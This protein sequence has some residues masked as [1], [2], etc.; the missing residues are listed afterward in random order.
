[1]NS[2]QFDGPLLERNYLFS[3][4]K[5]LTTFQNWLK[6][7]AEETLYGT[8]KIVNITKSMKNEIASLFD[9]T[10]DE[11]TPDPSFTET[12]YNFSIELLQSQN[13]FF[14]ILI[15]TLFIILVTPFII[16][17]NYKYIYTTKHTDEDVQ[18]TNSHKNTNIKTNP[19]C[20]MTTKDMNLYNDIA[21]SSLEMRL[22]TQ[23]SDINFELEDKKRNIEIDEHLKKKLDEFVKVP[24]ELDNVT[25]WHGKFVNTS[26]KY[27][28]PQ[29]ELEYIE[30]KTTAA[31]IFLELSK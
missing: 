2:C 15:L 23:V 11:K 29:N 14:I 26:D 30:K 28:N 27:K 25:D 6:I 18:T 13:I 3:I 24:S 5:I 1:M 22:F 8:E 16:L 4:C 7:S 12:I 21:Q 10:P 20:I 9:A 17:W 19:S 31:R